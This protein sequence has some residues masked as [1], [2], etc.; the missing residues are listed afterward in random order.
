[1]VVVM[2]AF[3]KSKD[4]EQEIIP[5]LVEGREGP[6]TPNVADRIDAPGYMMNQE[7]PDQAA[8]EQAEDGAQP[9]SREHEPKNRWDEQADCHPQRE[10]GIYLAQQSALPQ[11]LD[12][13]QQVGRVG[14]EKPANMRMPKSAQQAEHALAL[15]VRRVGIFVHIAKLVTPTVLGHPLQ[16]GAFDGHRT[17]DGQHKL[18]RRVGLKGAVRKQSVKADGYPQS[19]QHVHAEQKPEFNPMK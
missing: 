15:V 14:L 12:V 17:E 18:H 1:M 10:Q 4:A 11:V 19:R 16:D 2:P 7:D 9:G 6:A 13:A 3:A 8:P 5:A